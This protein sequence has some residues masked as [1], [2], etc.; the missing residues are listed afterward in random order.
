MVV[1]CI[2]H[3]TCH[4]ALMALV[5]KD[6]M[7]KDMG[8][9]DTAGFLCARRIEV[10]GLALPNIPIHLGKTTIQDARSVS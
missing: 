5:V 9:W 10:A 6:Y 8:F 7:P 4:M 3:S 2:L 1:P